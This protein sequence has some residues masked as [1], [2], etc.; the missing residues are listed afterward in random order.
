MKTMFLLWQSPHSRDYFSKIR[1]FQ[2]LTITEDAF[3]LAELKTV[4]SSCGDVNRCQLRAQYLVMDGMPVHPS[5]LRWLSQSPNLNGEVPNSRFSL[6]C[7]SKVSPFSTIPSSRRRW[8][9]TS[10]WCK[11]QT[12]PLK[13]VLRMKPLQILT[14]RSSWLLVWISKV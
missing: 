2:F 6:Q 5:N 14:T 1:L 10:R 3:C 9:I 8:R 11:S 13:F 12:K 7:I 4:I